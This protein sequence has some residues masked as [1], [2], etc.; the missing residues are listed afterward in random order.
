MEIERYEAD[1]KFFRS[2]SVALYGLLLFVLGKLVSEDASGNG[3]VR[4]ATILGFAAAVALP[5]WL[6][7]AQVWRD[8]REKRQPP[9]SERLPEPPSFWPLV[10]LIALVLL[11]SAVVLVLEGREQPLILLLGWALAL[12]GYADRRWK[13]TKAA[14]H[15]SVIL[16]EQA[17]PPQQPSTS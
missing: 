7:I 12:W 11:L 17:L 9:N 10:A 3:W 1:S 4:S 6:I 15:Y 16:Y 8:Q 14:Y 2:L 13:S 5:L